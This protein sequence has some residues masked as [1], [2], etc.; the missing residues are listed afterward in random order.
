MNRFPEQKVYLACD[1]W[2]PIGCTSV[3]GLSAAAIGI[4]PSLPVIEL[5]AS[6]DISSEAKIS[7]TVR[8]IPSPTGVD[9]TENT[10]L[11]NG[12]IRIHGASA[13]SYEKK[14]LALSL[15]SPTRWL[16]LTSGRQW[17]LNAA[18]VDCSLMRHKLSYDL[19]QSLS[20][21][22]VRRHAASS[23]FVELRLNGQYHGT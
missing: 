6:Q 19:F 20:S 21:D 7:C 1:V 17:V 8:W 4:V 9:R 11:L 23:R 12:K 3:R 18:Y 22:G 5:S 10:K 13:Q 16:G 14:S 15:D 2:T